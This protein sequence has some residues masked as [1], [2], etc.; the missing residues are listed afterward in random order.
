MER[1]LLGPGRQTD[2]QTWPTLEVCSTAIGVF[3]GTQAS[4]RGANELLII[5]SGMEAVEF[6][7]STYKKQALQL[8]GREIDSWK[9]LVVCNEDILNSDLNWHLE[10]GCIRASEQMMASK[11][12]NPGWSSTTSPPP[13]S[14]G[15]TYGIPSAPEKNECQCRKKEITLECLTLF[16][17]LHKMG[18][19]TQSPVMENTPEFVN[20][21]PNLLLFSPS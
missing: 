18:L 10:I 11:C 21:N 7:P 14:H 6:S 5:W 16:L 20:W 2:R 19:K 4:W 12:N 3:L 13:S 17:S 1:A 8:G 15:T 9:S